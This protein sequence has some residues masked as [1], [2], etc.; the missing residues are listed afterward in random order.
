MLRNRL[1][2]A[3]KVCRRALEQDARRLFD[4]EQAAAHAAKAWFLELAI[5]RCLEVAGHLA[6][7]P[8]QEA[9]P[10]IF[11][12]Q[13]S[14]ILK[15]CEVFREARA[16]DS[17]L[18]S[19]TTFSLLRRFLTDTITPDQWRE[20]HLL[21]WLSQYFEE[22]REQRR[23]GRFYTPEAI[24]A[25]IVGQT[26]ALLRES[27]STP[28]FRLLDLACG[29]GA[30]AL[31]AFDRMYDLWQNQPE[32]EQPESIATHILERQLF[33]IDCDP[34][35]CE[36][37][38]VNL[39]LKARR[40]EPT[41]RVKQMNVFCADALIRWE[42]EPSSPYRELFTQQ[43]DAVVGN[44]PYIVVNRLRTP[45]ER[46][47]LY[48]TYRAAAYKPNT[49][50]L[51]LERGLDLLAPDGALGMIVPNTLLTQLYFEPLRAHLLERAALTH[52]LDTKRLFPQAFVENCILLLQR[53]DEAA[54][55]QAQIIECHAAPLDASPASQTSPAGIRIPQRRFD[56]APFHR[57]SVSI[58]MP[59]FELLEKIAADSPKLGDIG[60]CHDG[61]NPGNAK[62]KLIVAEPVDARCKKVL[63]GKNIGRYWLNWGGLFVR[64]DRSLEAKGDV[65]RWGHLPSLNAPKILTRQT[66]D[67]IIA[68]LDD[69]QHYVTNSLHTTVL[70]AGVSDFG[71]KYLLGLLN[72][73]LLSF[74]YRKFVFE[75][76]QVFS[77]VKLMNLRQLPIKPA[78]P[79]QQREVVALVEQL[80]HGRDSREQADAQLDALVYQLYQLSSD[81]VR[82]IEQSMGVTRSLSACR[83]QCAV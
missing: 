36:L 6:V 75:T 53:Q 29:A 68:A 60:E 1:L 26:F 11:Y 63:N 5:L 48:A 7:L 37:A 59:T 56:S 12:A 3:V 16:A 28:S 14:L 54:K 71:L 17:F 67:R 34:L 35:A 82:V 83:T 27:R 47:A 65:I 72:S 24:A 76:G 32:R 40:R 19:S 38:R 33:L 23:H 46:L 2:A 49:F 10:G 81:D 77:Q 64:Y 55:R 31:Q 21:G 45:P 39:V 66:A 80:L 62:Q 58:D 4:D 30:F 51:F 13:T 25:F 22:Q 78:T 44:P 74:Y 79:E 50:A 15:T 69:G 18:P 42:H 57:F 61:V 20:D 73:T 41:C 70:R 43:Y 52:I 9:N 8:W